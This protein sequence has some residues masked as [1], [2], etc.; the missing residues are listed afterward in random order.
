VRVSADA[1][2]DTHRSP[3][4]W[5]NPA[6]AA[7]IPVP[8]IDTSP[9][10]GVTLGLIP[11]FLTTNSRNEI[12]RIIAPD[13][14]HSEY[15]G[16][17]GRFRVFGYPSPDVQWSLVGGGKQR[18]EREFDGRYAAGQQR[19]GAWT[20]SAELIYDRSGTPR[21]FGIG[22]TTRKSTETAYVASQARLDVM[23]G[24]NLTP[25]L[26][27]AYAGR[28]RDVEVLPGVFRGIPSIE[29]LHAAVSGV[30]HEHALQQLLVLSYDS[31][32]LAFIPRRGTRYVVYVG[33]ATRAL[34]SS[35]AYCSV[36][37]DARHYWPISARLSIAGHAGLRYLPV[38]RA[39]PFWALSSLGGDRSVYNEREPLRGFGAD[40]FIDRHL[41]ATGVELRIRA[42]NFDL[43][44]T[45]LALEVAPFIDAGKVFAHMGENPL[46]GLH[47][48][49]GIGFRGV[50]SPFVVGYVDIGYGP[51]KAAVFSGID[52][53]F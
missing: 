24:R 2:S 44:G 41:F 21:F 28:L 39:A 29:S 15:F 7:F 47:R 19:L 17:G 3:T 16:W 18:V 30:G 53:P 49:G 11:T 14:I 31:R 48:I 38:G 33:V 25:R 50:A 13:V 27:L 35:A 4:R 32:D 20:W 42:A 51:D 5:F 36:G 43:F 23:I 26:Q 34:L 12:V 52:Y 10:N 40:R 9:H 37:V 22:N 1:V 45:Q 46:R 6:T 8:E